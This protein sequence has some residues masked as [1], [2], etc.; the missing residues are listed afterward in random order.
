MN[1]LLAQLSAGLHRTSDLRPDV[2]SFLILHGCA[3]TARHCIAVADCAKQ[4][5]EQFG[6]DPR[7]AQT[8]GWLHDVSAVIPAARRLQA[9]REW[10][11][12]VLPAEETAP[13]LLHQKLSAVIAQELFD[14][15]DKDVLYAIGCHTTLRARASLLDQVVFVADKLAWD[16]PGTPPYQ[17]KLVGALAHALDHAVLCYLDYL[18]QQREVLAAVHPWFVEAYQ[19][20]KAVATRVSRQKTE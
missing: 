7:R 15:T 10:Q 1:P 19:E 3:K 12:E 4:L 17:Q 5:A 9:A 11:L 18:W 6:A 16:Q 2:I 8:A 14:I 13:M 20:H